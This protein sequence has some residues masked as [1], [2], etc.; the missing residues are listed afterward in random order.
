M[1]SRY[2]PTTLPTAAEMRIAQRWAAA[3]LTKPRPTRAPTR[4]TGQGPGLYV[5]HNHGDVQKNARAGAPLRIGGREFTRGLYCHAPSRVVV[6]LPGKGRRFEAHV[7]IDDH[8]NGGT[9]VFAVHAAGN[10]LYRSPVIRCHEAPVP[11][12]VALDGVEELTLEVSDAGDGITCDQANW[13]DAYAVL[14]DG[15]RVWLSDLP[16]LTE[17]PPLRLRYDLPFAFVYG[18]M[19]SDALL[20]TWDYAYNSVIVDASRTRHTF[21]FTEPGPGLEVVGEAVVYADFPTV[22]WTVRFHNR[23]PGNTRILENIRA[24]DVCFPRPSRESIFLRRWLGSICAVND[25]E[26]VVEPVP[27]DTSRRVATSGGRPTNS[28]MPYFNIQWSGGG[29]LAALGWPGQW[30][31]HFARDA[32]GVLRISGGQERTRFYLQPG[33]SVRGPLAVLQFYNGDPDRAQNVWRRWM[34]A[35]CVPRP[36]G[37]PIQPMMSA[38][39]GNH[40]PGIITNAAEEMR[41][42]R[43]YLQHGIR[44]DFWWQDA[45]WYPCDPVGWPKTGTWEVDRTRWP[46]GIREVSDWARDHGIETILWFEP[47][48]VHSGTWLAEN[49]PE[50]VAGGKNGGLLRIGDPQCRAWL[51]ETID[52]LIREQ[53]IDVYRQDFNI[54]PLSYW[55]ADD[56]D[57][58]EGIAEIRHVEGYLAFW[59]ELLR[60]HPSM[61]IDSCASG[62]RR[63]DLETLRRAVPLLR[64]DYTFDPVGEQCHTYG[65]ASWI[66]FH[67]TGFLTVDTYLIRSQMSPEFTLGVDTRREDL[68]YTTL[69][70]LIAEWRRLS[71][72]LLADFWPLTPYSK[73]NDTWMAWQFDSPERGEGFI[74]AFRRADCIEEHLTVKPRGL[75][76]TA[77][78]ELED[79]DAG[80]IG[81]CTGRVLARDGFTFRSKARPEAR[82]V[83][84][85]Q[86]GKDQSWN[87]ARSKEPSGH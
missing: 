73:S 43:G 80:T 53:G 72:C 74:Q 81:V 27:P 68:D 14:A 64:S 63:N 85:R 45:G 78:Y 16:L 79:M 26:P 17:Q 76:P 13:A 87:G 20:P 28:D 50:W 23:G 66:P 47:E 54:D 57:G 25:Y 44:P 82:T 38:C 5:I 41:F 48:R 75:V 36:D 65:I 37:K 10:E 86:V 8:A 71:P 9:V 7:G 60:R 52:R 34:M 1:A 59:D 62:G 61:L 11:V 46:S 12:S 32:G 40:Y 2:R 83:V 30:S 67:G 15:R 33:E 4:S 70:K 19:P 58:R 6:R 21:R 39:N 22:E 77:T 31:A 55:Q 69:R 51:V 24:L 18:G 35:H 56:T 42:L 29:V 84:Y 3:H 49:R